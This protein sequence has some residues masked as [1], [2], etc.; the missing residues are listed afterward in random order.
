MP[1]CLLYIIIF[2]S[3][4]AHSYHNAFPVKLPPQPR[5]I[6]SSVSVF[7]ICVASAL[8]GLPISAQ[9][10]QPSSSPEN[11]SSNHTQ[12]SLHDLVSKAIAEGKK[13]VKLPGGVIQ[14]SKALE[15]QRVQ[16]F[17][18]D[19]NGTTLVMS[20]AKQAILRIKRCSKITIRNLRLDY[21]PL[22]F[23]QGTVIQAGKQ[24]IEFEVHAGYPEITPAFVGSAAHFFTSDGRRHPD[25]FDFYKP[26]FEALSPSRAR[27]YFPDGLRAELKPGDLIAL[28]RRFAKGSSSAVEIRN[29]SGPV[30]FEDITLHASPGLCFVGRYNDEAVTFRRVTVSPGAPP[31]GASQARLLSSNADGV[32]FAQ[33]RRGPVLESCDF[34]GMGD[35]SFNV[36]GFFM[37]IVQVI[38]PTRFV[39]AYKYQRE[40]IEPIRGGDVLRL[41]N[42]GNFSQAGETTLVSITPVETDIQLSAE[43]KEHLFHSF[44]PVESLAFY[45]VDISQPMKVQE[46]QWFDIPAVNCQG[47]VIR[48]SYFHD[49]RARGLRLMAGDGVVE[50]N[51]FE[52][53]TKTAISIGPELGYWRES[54]WVKNVRIIG[55]TL[56]DI[57]VDRSLAASG[58]YAPGAISI[59]GRTDVAAKDTPPENR[60]IRIVGNQIKNCTVAGIYGYGARDVVVRNNVLI[61]TNTV[62][63]A[64]HLDAQAG[65]ST[66]GP[67]S[68]SAVQNLVEE[69]NKVGDSD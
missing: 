29:C 6:A 58:S 66:P 5:R 18:I 67:I 49:H 7:M 31:A 24:M 48:D 40:I 39:T 27:V 3:T 9:T 1:G 23:T 35:D 8:A 38:S 22:P 52:R 37:P 54:G 64:G 28:D 41:F 32:N 10:P 25:T 13:T 46:G 53:L 43:Q 51:R 20:D 61:N 47:Y 65:L 56:H 16:D 15:L 2:S 14:M 11:A 50:N 60:D 57:G 63:K 34:S 55:N 26:K 36:H 44:G 69:N 21:A 4:V 17:E 33:C 30:L 19:G 68:L 62:R 42:Q 59:F 45:Q 12:V